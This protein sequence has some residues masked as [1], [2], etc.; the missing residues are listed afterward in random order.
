MT[1]NPKFTPQYKEIYPNVWICIAD[2]DTRAVVGAKTSRAANLEAR[3]SKIVTESGEQEWGNPTE[4]VRA[5]TER[6]VRQYSHASIAEMAEAFVHV[7]DLGWPTAYL[8]EDFPLF[9]G[10]EVSTRAVDMTKDPRPAR[11]APAEALE[12]HHEWLE[13]FEEQKELLSESGGYKFDNIRWA[14][15]G[16]TRSGVTF[17]GKVRSMVRHIEEV[18]TLGDNYW[19][20]SDDFMRGI[21]AYAP[22]TTRG[23]QRGERDHSVLWHPPVVRMEE[24]DVERIQKKRGMTAVRPYGPVSPLRASSLGLVKEREPRQHLDKAFKMLGQFHVSIECSV[25]AARDWH[26]HRAVMPWRLE[27]LRDRATDDLLISPFYPE[28]H[29]EKYAELWRKTSELH[30]TVYDRHEWD[31]L[32][33]LPFGSMVRMS[34]VGS[35]PDVLYMLE[36]RYSAGGANFEYKAQARQGLIELAQ[37]L[38]VEDARALNILGTLPEAERERIYGVMAS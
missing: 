24:R 20:L 33:C 32:F 35:L 13:V 18:A 27:I 9:V 12:V 4:E 28:A 36:L 15:P 17:A 31:S 34:C 16:T 30:R 25:A 10:Q 6:N 22:V 26:R 5:F 23:I 38:G 29:D 14:L 1:D 7:K 3:W 37:A 21:Q 11:H 19:N 8:V 2:A